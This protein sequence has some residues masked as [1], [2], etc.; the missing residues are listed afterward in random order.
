MSVGFSCR[1][2]VGPSRGGTSCR[3]GGPD[4]GDES[5]EILFLKRGR[6]LRLH[7]VSWSHGGC[8]RGN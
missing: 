5:R 6:L 1:C 8:E 2:V 7:R 3:F 4:S